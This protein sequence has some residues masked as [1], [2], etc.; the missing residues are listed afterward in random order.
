MGSYCIFAFACVRRF[1]FLDF[2]W[3][4]ACWCVFLFCVQN[5]SFLRIWWVF[6]LAG[7]VFGAFSSGLGLVWASRGGLWA[8]PARGSYPLNL[9]EKKFHLGGITWQGR[10]GCGRVEVVSGGICG[11]WLLVETVFA[12]GTSRFDTYAPFFGGCLMPI[13]TSCLY[14]KRR[15]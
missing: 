10:C 2:V 7:L 11:I 3:A 6:G 4:W 14:R 9:C 5:R 1:C 15:K 8:F 13:Y 12:V